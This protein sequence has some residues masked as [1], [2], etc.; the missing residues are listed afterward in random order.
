MC[1][2]TRRKEKCVNL[3]G[4]V[5]TNRLLI[6]PLW[7]AELGVGVSESLKDAQRAMGRWKFLGENA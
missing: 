6:D 2:E 5:L 7:I 1:M 4:A 3:R